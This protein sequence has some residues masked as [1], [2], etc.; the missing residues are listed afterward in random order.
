[1]FR[2]ILFLLIPSLAFASPPARVSSYSPNTTISST[3]VTANENALFNYVQAGVDTYADSTIF[4]ADIAS[5][6]NIQSDKLNLTS[7]AQNISN[8]GTFANTGNATITGTLTVS[9][10]VTANGVVYAMLPAGIIMA[11]P[12]T[13]APNGWLICDG[14]AVSRTT[15]SGLFSAI[16]T[17][18][19]IGDGTTTFNVPDLK[20]RSIFGKNT[21]TFSSIAGTGGAETV[22][23]SQG[24]LPSYNLSATV[25]NTNG[26]ALTG[27]Q[28][29][30]NGATASTANI[31]SGGSGTATNILNPYLV[32][33]YVIKY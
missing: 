1:M 20:G 19:G 2:L 28:G 5:A 14:T 23:I 27:I 12:T 9:S 24:N 16:G 7:V 6:A 26:S 33:N 3:A 29:T 32:L 8:T 11:W 21:G 31:A 18:F 15:Y 10:N 25:Y 17:A 22:T 13:T 4:N 30:T